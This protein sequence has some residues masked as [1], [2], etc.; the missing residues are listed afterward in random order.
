MMASEK[1]NNEPSS[2]SGSA[3]GT[4]GSQNNDKNIILFNIFNVNSHEYR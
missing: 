3:F 2:G 4:I 1:Y